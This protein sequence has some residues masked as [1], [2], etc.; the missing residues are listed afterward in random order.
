MKPLTERTFEMFFAPIAILAIVVIA[1][2]QI[3]VPTSNA[4]ATEIPPLQGAVITMDNGRQIVCHGNI[5][6][7]QLVMAGE[8]GT[9]EY[10]NMAYELLGRN[11]CTTIGT[12][13]VFK[14][15]LVDGP[16]TLISYHDGRAMQ[17]MAVETRWLSSVF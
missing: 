17:L 2:V 9:M 4:A 7:R 15:V 8:P 13:Q 6:I 14:V 16:V 11:A 5:S 1:A 10:Q 12:G 3:M